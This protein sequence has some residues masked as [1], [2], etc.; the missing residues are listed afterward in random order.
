MKKKEKNLFSG[1]FKKEIRRGKI[2]EVDVKRG[3]IKDEI[4]VKFK[5]NKFFSS[6]G[7]KIKVKGLKLNKMLDKK[8]GI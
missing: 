7:D 6:L 5:M 8:L 1:S 2:I 3:Y 4:I